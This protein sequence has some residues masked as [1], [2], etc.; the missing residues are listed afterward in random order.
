MST[1][2]TNIAKREKSLMAAKAIG[3]LMAIAVLAIVIFS[4]KHRQ[5]RLVNKS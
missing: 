2:K 3:S 4:T 5:K 1:M